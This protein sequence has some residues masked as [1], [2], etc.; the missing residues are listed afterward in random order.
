MGDTGLGLERGEVP[1]ELDL[2]SGPGRLIAFRT[3]VRP[4]QTALEGMPIVTERCADILG[5]P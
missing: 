4:Y 3:R 1:T 5:R 2:P